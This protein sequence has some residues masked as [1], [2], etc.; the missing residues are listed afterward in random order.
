MKAPGMINAKRHAPE[1]RATMGH[2]TVRAAMGSALLEV[3]VALAIFVGA[4]SAILSAAHRG[5]RFLAQALAEEQAADLARSA[6]SAVEIGVATPQSV[7]TLITEDGGAPRLT[8]DADSRSASPSSGDGR[9]RLTVDT[10]PGDEPGFVLLTVT[11]ERTADNGRIVEVSHTIRQ[12]V[13]AETGGG[14]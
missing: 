10:Q 6:I 1:G 3:V 4:G 9:W 8:V 7:A 2:A 13:R 11:A 12:L 14:K 5:E